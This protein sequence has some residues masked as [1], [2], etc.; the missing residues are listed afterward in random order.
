MPATKLF[1][2][3][4]LPFDQSNDRTSVT[5]DSGTQDMVPFVLRVVNP[6]IYEQEED[7]A[8]LNEYNTPL[9]TTLSY[10]SDTQMQKS[11]STFSEQTTTS[12][13]SS[14]G[15]PLLSEYS[16]S[17][18]TNLSSPVIRRVSKVLVEAPHHKGPIDYLPPIDLSTPLLTT[19]ES[20]LLSPTS[21]NTSPRSEYNKLPP[22]LPQHHPDFLSSSPKTSAIVAQQ[23]VN[24]M[25]ISTADIPHENKPMDL[26]RHSVTEPHAVFNYNEQSDRRRSKDLLN[27]QK[28]RTMSPL[29]HN[30]ISPSIRSA[31]ITP[32]FSPSTVISNHS[33][34]GSSRYTKASYSLTNHP[35]AIKLY[36]TMA[37]KTGD[38]MVQ[39]TYAK[40]LLEVSSL[41]DSSEERQ[42]FRPKISLTIPLLKRP[43]IRN[44]G[45]SSADSRRSSVDTSASTSFNLMK[46][47]S[48][49]RRPSYQPMDEEEAS[50]RK[51]KKMLEEEGVR[52][53][54]RLSKKHIGEAAYLMGLWYEHGMYGFNVSSTKAIKYYE[55][56]ATDKIPEAMYSVAQFHEK[57]QDYMTSFKLYEEAASLGLVEALY[58]LAMI[59]L[60]G[61]FGSRRN[62]NAAIQLLISASEKSTGSCPEAPYTL[63]LVLTNE[64]PSV[65]IPSE[66]IQSYGGT[67]A[68]MT[69]LEAAADMGMAEALFRLG[70]IYERGIYNVRININKAFTYYESVAKNN[71]GAEGMLGL[72]R[73][74]NQGVQVPQEEAEIQ[75]MIYEQDESNWKQIRRRDED[76]AFIWCRKAADLRLVDAYYLL[77]F[78]YEMGV[79]VPRDYKQAHYYYNKA[80]KRGHKY[81]ENRLSSLNTMLRN[82]KSDNRQTNQDRRFSRKD[83]QCNIM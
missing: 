52:W 17:K 82:Q 60:N 49:E 16:H 68:A 30:S 81:A 4:A 22:S 58:R 38:L 20:H 42:S 71:E 34:N 80:V 1:P 55:M 31:S 61:E 28:T 75:R 62:I 66:L 21:S 33:N 8:R 54:K 15:Q 7:D 43:D 39:L 45:R 72:S 18:Y 51:K 11:K 44:M 74:Y 79:G 2:F 9:E 53:I 77:G 40:Y 12:A 47:T 41:Y 83:T 78:Y 50:K 6:D 65:N 10:N 32:S 19:N 5:S 23:S 37:I 3:N 36:R 25:V 24:A 48:N 35:D 63:A 56:A 27:K 46:I 57:E 76:E 73:I 67:F 13:N 69:Y 70:Y 14:P 64:Y 26:S 59:H 29:L